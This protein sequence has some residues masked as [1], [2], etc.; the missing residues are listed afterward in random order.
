[1]SSKSREVTRLSTPSDRVDPGNCLSGQPA[2]F[3]GSGNTYSGRAVVLDYILDF[4]LHWHRRRHGWHCL[5][6][7]PVV[8][9][10]KGV[11]A[12]SEETHKS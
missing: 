11:V 4:L 5:E 8:D 7:K 6:G 10:T 2:Q 3:L 12:G 9:R 1:M